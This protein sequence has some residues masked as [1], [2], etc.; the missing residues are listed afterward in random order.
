MI[1]DLE[2]RLRKIEQAIRGAE[3]VQWRRSD[4]EK[5]ALADDMVTKLRDGIAKAEADV[6]QARAAGDNAKVAKLEGEL[7]NRRAFLAMAE[8]TAAEFSG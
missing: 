7:E 1:S 8:K 6:E 3:D 5:S 4:P 2:G